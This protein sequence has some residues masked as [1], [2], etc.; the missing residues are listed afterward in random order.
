MQDTDN[1]I[2]TALDESQKEA[3]LAIRGPLL[4]I[5]GA[6]SGKTRVLTA[7][8]AY[9][10]QQGV[11]PE[12]ILALTFTRKAAEEMRR[13][14]ASSCGAQQAAR[15]RMGTFHSVFITFLR[16][17]ASLLG[18]PGAFTILDEDDAR[19][20]MRRC[21]AAVLAAHRPPHERWTKAQESSFRTEDGYYKAKDCLAR[22]AELKSALVTDAAYR[23]EASLTAQDNARHRPLMGEIYTEYRAACLRSGVMDFDDILMYTD[24]LMAN[25]PDVEL[26][27]SSSFDYILVDEYQD[28][29]AAQYSILRRLTRRNGNICAVGDDSQSI[30]A[31][32]GARIENILGFVKDY[33]A[34]RT[35]RLERN[36][37]S[38]G[39]IVEAANQLI[40][41]N[42]ERIPKVC[43]TD[44]GEGD[45][46]ELVEADD[47]RIEAQYVAETIAQAR[48]KGGSG[49]DFAVLYRTNAQ[50]RMLEEALIHAKI[51]YTIYS[52][53]SFFDRMEVRDQMAYFTLAVNPDNDEALR[54]IA[55][56]PV[57]GLGDTAMTK[58]AVYARE[59]GVSLWKAIT[60]G[61]AARLQLRRDAL[62]GFERL[63]S[64]IEECMAVARDCGAWEAATRIADMAGFAAAYRAEGD[65]EALARADNIRE[66]T[67]AV[68]AYEDETAES[69]RLLEADRRQGSTLAGF[70]QNALLL[71]NADTRGADGDSVSLMTVHCAK[72][73]E[74]P[75]VFV[76]G[77]EKGLFPL[78][79]DGTRQ[80]EE[81]ERRLFYV[82]V[83][84][85]E[86]R[87]VLTRAER[88]L[89]FGK[90]TKTSPSKFIEE[91]MGELQYE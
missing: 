63:R 7:R 2:L 88:R 66:L 75:F 23:A 26:A 73:L 56:R 89:R 30:Y 91:L 42:S 27:L 54:R 20:M 31:F 13:R 64:M 3:V 29:N 21:A 62:E 16:P 1:S 24:M 68:K 60:S 14:V 83:T 52:G 69:D 65:A 82:A 32:R 17:Y 55:N 50:S 46:I 90:K 71:S 18:Y 51:P 22:V 67:D 35:V 80:E 53:T 19:S 4:V 45:P 39:S 5:A 44:N 70:L 10:L 40:E 47:D 86:R 15:L 11:L 38:T 6:G 57:R 87:L 37:R 48:A 58:M 72:G 28:T 81:E 74:F 41:Y 78:A 61:A 84:R 77:M 34:A 43:F 12:R 25:N 79:I 8:I 49:G 76:T 9:L 59:A 85:A 36:Y 33:P